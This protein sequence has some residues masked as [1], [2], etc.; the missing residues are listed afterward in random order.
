VVAASLRELELQAELSALLG[1]D[2]LTLHAGGAAGGKPA[3]LDRLERGLD[4]L[5]PP[6]RALVA[7]ENDD[8]TFTPVDLLPLCERAG[9]PF[10]YDVHHH[11]CA[12]DGMSV[13]EATGRGAATWRGRG[14]PWMHLSS[15]RVPWGTGDPRP[16]A[17][18]ID[19]A[20]LPAEWPGMTI[21]VD[22]EAKAKE[23]AVLQIREQ[24]R[25]GVVLAYLPDSRIS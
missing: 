12:P 5:S 9:I 14:E 7:L 19:P 2:A 23:R 24:S 6:A 25:H 1:A 15:P 20:D 11:R 10:V 17:D 18:Y 22:V 16:H 21:T 8:R 13:A 4:R 3:A